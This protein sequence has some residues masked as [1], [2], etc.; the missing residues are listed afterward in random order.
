MCFACNEFCSFVTM[1]GYHV[2][3]IFTS[4]FLLSLHINN[5]NGCK[6]SAVTKTMEGKKKTRYLCGNEAFSVP[7][8]RLQLKRLHDITDYIKRDFASFENVQVREE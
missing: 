7:L 1:S 8:Y 3:I 5:N 4:K 6:S 2:V